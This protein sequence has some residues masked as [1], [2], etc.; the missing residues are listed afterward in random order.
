[1]VRGGVE[2]GESRVGCVNGRS[3]LDQVSDGCL[4]EQIATVGAGN[5]SSRSRH[6]CYVEKQACLY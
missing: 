2:N 6:F 5:Q 3:H 1:M 4:D